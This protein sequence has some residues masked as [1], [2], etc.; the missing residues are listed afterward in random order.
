MNLAAWYPSIKQAHVAL[1]ALSGALFVLRGAAVVAGARWPRRPAWRIASVVIDT[2]LLG[3]GATL[4]A[5]LRLDLRAA[6]WLAVKLVLLVVYVVL[7]TLALKGDKPA[8][9][10]ALWLASALIVFATMVSV[11]LAHHPLG[12]WR[13]V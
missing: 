8:S 5:L 12:F 9:V 10:R 4:W 2:L 7:G 1:V 13:L 6:P 11:A 3:A